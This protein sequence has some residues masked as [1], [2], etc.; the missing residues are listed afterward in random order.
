MKYCPLCR[1][2]YRH[3]FVTCA[4]CGATLVPS[5]ESDEMRDNPAR[6]LWVGRDFIEFDL[7]ACALRDAQIPANVEQGLGGLLGRVLNSQSKIH[8]LEADFA[9]A[10]EIA[11]AAIKARSVGRGASQACHSCSAEC[12]ASLT[13]CP[14]CKTLLIIERKADDGKSAVT[15]EIACTDRR[16]CPLCDAAY[17]GGHKRCSVCGVDLVPEELRGRPLSDRERNEPIEVVWRGGDP[18]AVSEVI[19]TLR[20]V[21]IRHHVQ[22]TN[23]HL[24]FELA[25]P[26]PKFVARVFRSDAARAR[27]LLSGVRESPLFGG[28]QTL[29]DEA[30][31]AA[32][33]ERGKSE[34]N[35]AAAV[36][37]IWSGEDAALAQL[38]EDCLREN[39]IGVRREGREPGTMR[40][41]V[42]PQ[43]E[44]AAHEIVRQVREASPPV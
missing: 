38:L 27:E 32:K 29:V 11:R 2:A 7:V 39:Q 26:R 1:A 9:P 16:H 44:A 30:E 33:V 12:S 35:P 4:T 36:T 22:P 43:D 10:L 28:I 20:E 17:A 42:M 34:W 19:N 8:V 21:G 23:D 5:L 3:G 41:S 31:S 6:L 18:L 40:L 37:E 24:V 25:M 13:A 14:T 15:I